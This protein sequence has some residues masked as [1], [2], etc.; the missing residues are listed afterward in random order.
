M[1]P[2]A[3]RVYQEYEQNRGDPK[4]ETER[5]NFMNSFKS[6]FCRTERHA[7]QYDRNETISDNESG[8]K[9]HFLGLFDCVNSVGTLD[10]P[11]WGKVPPLPKVSG[12]ARY[13]RHAVAIDERRVKFK[14]ALFAQERTEVEDDIK[15]VW[16][17]GNHG[18]IGGGW[19]DVTRSQQ[20][21]TTTQIDKVGSETCKSY[22]ASVV[23]RPIA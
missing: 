3:Y 11:F 1:V 17:P 20:T 9:V 8:I 16:F 6:H 12:T 19:S 7:A 23:Y 18:D 4:L 14:P 13:V 10:I 15:E 5:A 21:G 2:F 22:F